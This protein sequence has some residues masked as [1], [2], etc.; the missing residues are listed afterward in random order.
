[1]HFCGQQYVMHEYNLFLTFRFS[2][3]HYSAIVRDLEVSDYPVKPSLSFIMSL[4]L[5]LGL[6]ASIGFHTIKFIKEFFLGLNL[7]HF[8]KFLIQSKFKTLMIYDSFVDYYTTGTFSRFFYFT[9]P[10][11]ILI[12][13]KY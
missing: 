4:F 13:R 5:M 7:E 12:I 6:L 1:M 3:C 8:I 9:R 10:I 2:Y 11:Y